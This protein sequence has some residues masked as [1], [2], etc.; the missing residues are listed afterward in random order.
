VRR[1][2]GIDFAGTDSTVFGFLGD[3]VLDDP[4]PMGTTFY[5]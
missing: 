3:V 2:A 5:K 1:A 4:P